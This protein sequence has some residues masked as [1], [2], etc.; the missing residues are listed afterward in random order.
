[1]NTTEH[2]SPTN[3]LSPSDPRA[4]FAAAVGTAGEVIATVQPHQTGLPTPCADID[5]SGMFGHLLMV[6]E[7]VAALGAGRDPMDLPDEKE[8]PL[9]GWTAEWLAAAHRVQQAWTD[10]EV[11]ERQMWLPWAEGP[12]GQMLGSYTAELTVHTW[13]LATALGHGVEWD[14]R[15]LATSWEVYQAMLPPGDRQAR[16][17]EVRAQMPPEYPV[18]P[19]PFLDAVD[20][21]ADAPLIERIVAWTGRQPASAA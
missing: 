14:A 7:R 18:G 17:D 15:A 9:A 5:V 19:P 10:P 20:L 21:P 1:M 3:T 2:V 4:V 8:V 13:D 6:L 11:L 16:F 12:G